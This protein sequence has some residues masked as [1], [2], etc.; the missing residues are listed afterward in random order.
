MG[1]LCPMPTLETTAFHCPVLH[2]C[3]SRQ[4]TWREARDGVCFVHLPALTER[5]S[6]IYLGHAVAVCLFLSCLLICSS[7]FQ[8]PC[9]LFHCGGTDFTGRGT[10]SLRRSW[11]LV[12]L[13][14]TMLFSFQSEDHQST[15]PALPG[16]RVRL[17]LTSRIIYLNQILVSSL[18]RM[19]YISYLFCKV[20]NPLKCIFP[21]DQDI[22]EGPWQPDMGHSHSHLRNSVLQRMG[23]SR[24]RQRQC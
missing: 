17:A 13:G 6:H 18:Q 15:S 1:K 16:L 2:T 10:V 5:V 12:V 24:F 8:S 19:T 20:G 7:L 9:P 23:L 21:E 3:R 11:V 22:Q 14:K 4:V